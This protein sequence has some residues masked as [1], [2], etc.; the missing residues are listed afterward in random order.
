MD[1]AVIVDRDDADDR[2]AVAIAS[3][4]RSSMSMAATPTWRSARSDG[5]LPATSTGPDPAQARTL[6]GSPGTAGRRC[7]ARPELAE[8]PHPG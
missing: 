4:P 7:T 8:F 6:I 1:L 3:I 2:S 5:S